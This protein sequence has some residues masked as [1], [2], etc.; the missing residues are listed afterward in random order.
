ME[1]SIMNYFI[2][3]LYILM[4]KPTI[5][6][7]KTHASKFGSVYLWTDKIFSAK[8]VMTVSYEQVW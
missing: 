4:N 3:M 6:G 8:E 2:N 5:I 1:Q 7:S